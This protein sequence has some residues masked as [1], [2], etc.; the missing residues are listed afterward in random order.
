MVAILV[1]GSRIKGGGVCRVEAGNCGE[2]TQFAAMSF[3]G[4]DGAVSA[5]LA[6][7]T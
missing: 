2:V 6:T 3:E 5:M 4:G 7:G 1:S